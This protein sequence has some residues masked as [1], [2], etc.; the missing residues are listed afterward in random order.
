MPSQMAE[1][2]SHIHAIAN[3]VKISSSLRCKWQS[4]VRMGSEC[5][6]EYNHIQWRSF[7]F[8]EHFFIF[9]ILTHGVV[10]SLGVDV[11]VELHEELS[12]V[13]VLVRWL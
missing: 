10:W 8:R 1:I 13:C 11:I 6:A 3:T 2:H 5:V 9:L 12:V 7:D 4:V